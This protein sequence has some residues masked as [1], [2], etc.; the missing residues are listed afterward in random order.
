MGAGSVGKS[1]PELMAELAGELEKESGRAVVVLTAAHLDYLLQRLIT[2]T[3]NLPEDA[4]KLLFEGL[5]GPGGS[6]AWKTDMAF[7]LGLLTQP[8]KDDLVL[9]RRMRNAFA[10]E[11]VGLSFE[12]PKIKDRCRELKSAQIDGM[13]ICPRDQYTKAVVRLMVE[14]TV[15][16]SQAEGHTH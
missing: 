16:V 4:E 13:P 8:Q 6:F 9:I 5:T 2:L 7:Y 11:L 1:T 10:H 12:T 15:L 3:W 14:L